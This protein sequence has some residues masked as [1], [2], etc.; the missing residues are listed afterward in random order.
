MDFTRENIIQLH[1]RIVQFGNENF[2]QIEKL[3]LDPNDELDSTYVGML[4][5]QITI[6]NDLA[7]LMDNKNH[8]YHTS[9]FILLRC[10]IDDYLHITYIVN[11]DNSEEVIVDFNADA[12]EKN[13]KK[14][15]DLAI[16]NEETLGGNYPHYPTY[17]LMEEVK[18]KIKNSPKRQQH[19]SDKENFKFKKFKNTGQIIRDLKDEVY[20]HSLRRAYFIWRKLSDFVH[21]S[22]TAFE[23]EEMID[24]ETDSTY[25]EFAEIISYSYFTI[26]NC[27]K[28]FQN[29]YNLEIIDTNKLSVYYK[30]VEYRN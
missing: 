26:L 27:F 15:F 30:D 18:E 5:R 16:L 9:E 10:L 3:N 22:N 1:K 8:G 13:F 2:A 12:L 28:H 24:P 25:T 23:E 6:N 21:Y 7:L 17:A 4:L 14:I 11:Q 20:S 19:F 29:R